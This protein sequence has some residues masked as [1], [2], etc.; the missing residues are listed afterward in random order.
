MYVSRFFSD[1]EFTR[2][3]PSCKRED[4]CEDSLRRLDECRAL[5]GCPFILNSAYRPRQYELAKG[6]S[7]NS[8]HTLGRAFDIRCSDNVQRYRIV[9]AA[10]ACGF[11]RIGIGR[12]FIHLDDAISL[13]T[14]RIW[15]Y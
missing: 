10:I 9:S 13:P 6:R 11:N 1:E 8:A 3:K 15:L 12:G 14:H 7:G 4:I 5:A 2:C